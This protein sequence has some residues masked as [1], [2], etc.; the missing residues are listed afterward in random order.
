M[1]SRAASEPVRASGAGFLVSPSG[2]EVK[3]RTGKQCEAL[4]IDLRT[5]ATSLTAPF[6]RSHAVR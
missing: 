6:P 4:T 2:S 1:P 5:V 3:Q